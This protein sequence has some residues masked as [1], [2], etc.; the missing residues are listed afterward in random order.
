MQLCILASGS[1]ANS[2]LLRDG[3]TRILIDAGLGIRRLLAALAELGEQPAGLDAIFL[4]HEHADHTRAL[5]RLQPYADIPA[6]GSAGTLARLEAKAHRKQRFTAM[7]SEAIDVGCFTVQAIPVSHDAAEPSGFS[8]TANQDRITVATDL[9][10]VSPELS[11]ALIHSAC[12]V[13]ESNHDEELLE[14]GPY[15]QVLKDRIRS[16]LGHL[17]NR[18]TAEALAACRD[19][20]LRHVVLAHISED[21]NDP[22]L[23]KSFA[24]AALEGCEVEVHLTTQRTLGPILEL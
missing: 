17:S 21:N 7:N 4:T 9:G 3:D 16:S 11:G 13:L 15:P 8:I 14:C 20:G 6:Y 12:I 2:L 5:N 1:K 18:Q 22:L 23:A 19:N 10:E 24:E